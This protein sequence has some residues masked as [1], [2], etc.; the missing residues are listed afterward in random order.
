[1]GITR[2]RLLAGAVGVAAAP[3]LQGCA[4]PMPALG[5]STTTAEAASLLAESAAAHG[6]TAFAGIGD[7]SLA[8]AGQW[9]RVVAKLQPALVDSGFRGGSEERLLLRENVS[10]QFYTGPKGRK[11]ALRHMGNDRSPGAIRVWFN[12]EEAHDAERLDAAAL[13]A[14][15]YA[16]F[17]LGPLLI[18]NQWSRDRRVVMQRLGSERLTQAGRSDVC[19]ILRLRVTPGLGNSAADDLQLYIDRNARLMRRVVFTLNGLESTRGAIAR[20]DTFDHDLKFGV[21]WPTRFHEHLVRPFPLSV[22]DWRLTGLDVNRGLR[23]GEVTGP[24]AG[25]RAA[26]PAHAL[27]HS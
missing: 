16:L 20:V 19:D 23:V 25:G 4:S 12:G 13:V 14:D 18:E 8:Y 22:H 2:R 6:S 7:I 5:A 17:L 26:T 10:A 3:L 1:M 27:L 11:A 21:R 9:H 15:G 24:D